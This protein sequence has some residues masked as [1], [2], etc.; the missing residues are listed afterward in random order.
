MEDMDTR[1]VC[2]EICKEHHLP[3]LPLLSWMTPLC[4]P[5]HS[6]KLHVLALARA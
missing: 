4:G 6:E 2:A 1:S 5:G 3:R